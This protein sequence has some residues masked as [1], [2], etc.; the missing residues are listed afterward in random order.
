[1]F[2]ANLQQSVCKAEPCVFHIRLS[3]WDVYTIHSQDC[4]EKLVS[5]ACSV[6]IYVF[7]N[8]F[9][10]QCNL[11][12]VR[13][14]KL[15]R[16]VGQYG[17][18]YWA[19]DRGNI[20]EIIKDFFL[21]WTAD[22]STSDETRTFLLRE[23]RILNTSFCFCLND[24]LD[25]E[26]SLQQ[27]CLNIYSRGIYSLWSRQT[28]LY[29]SFHSLLYPEGKSNVFC[30]HRSSKTFYACL[31]FFFF[32]FFFFYDGGQCCLTHCFKIQKKVFIWD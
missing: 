11:L 19:C 29:I 14:K 32:F 13:E 7:I 24:R 21:P 2:N 18:N 16:G 9:K 23:V 1:M 20:K 8:L 10:S 25:P 6:F 17:A 28:Y 12:P 26:I 5:M 27:T 3:V 22:Q 15:W 31:V 30:Q 4:T